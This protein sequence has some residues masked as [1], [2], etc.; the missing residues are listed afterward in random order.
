MCIYLKNVF[1]MFIY[2]YCIDNIYVY[3]I[4]NICI[5]Y[6][7]CIVCILY[8]CIL[9][10]KYREIF[11]VDFNFVCSEL[12]DNILNWFYVFNENSDHTC[13]MSYNKYF[14]GILIKGIEKSSLNV[15][16]W[17]SNICVILNWIFPYSC[18]V[19]MFVFD[20]N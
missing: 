7:H 15:T 2:V 20:P 14:I 6:I 5:L 1:I 18:N 4:L 16:I 17:V 13:K 8:T 3:C 11:S 12:F 10:T 19:V 9:Y